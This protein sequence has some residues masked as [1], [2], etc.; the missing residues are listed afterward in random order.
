MSLPQA[1]IERSQGRNSGETHRQ[2]LKQ[3][4]CR[5]VVYC[6]AQPAFLYSPRPLL[7][8]STVHRVLEPP[9]S[10]PSAPQAC[11]WTSLMEALSL[12][13]FLFLTWLSNL[14]QND[15]KQTI[16]QTKTTTN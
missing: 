15:K 8:G 4:L 1:I 16:K 7:G 10:I 2:E 11:L 13:R 6:F 3:G 12:L 14:G 9:T 5:N